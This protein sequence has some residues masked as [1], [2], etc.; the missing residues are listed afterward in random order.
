MPPPIPFAKALSPIPQDTRAS[1]P[2]YFGLIVDSSNVPVDSDDNRH[3][4]GG[5]SPPSSSV[6]STA[7]PSPRILPLDANPEFEAFRR[8]SE[9]HAF[10]LGQGHLSQFSGSGDTRNTTPQTPSVQPRDQ[11][12][13]IS[14]NSRPAVFNRE[15]SSDQ[16][17]VDP[18]RPF[19][20]SSLTLTR[21]ESPA[22]I[23]PGTPASAQR[24]EIS[25]LD[26]R[27]P[28][29]SLPH[30]RV[31]APSPL[32]LSN[33][34]HR[35]AT[36]PGKATNDD[37]RM[38]NSPDLLNLMNADPQGLLLLD[39]RVYSQFSQARIWNAL[40]LCISTTLL[41]R[42]SFT[43]NK[44]AETFSKE[45]D[46]IKFE[47][48]REVRHIV[49]YDDKSSTIRDAA[50]AVNTLKKFPRD[51]TQAQLYILQGGF[52]AFS[53]IYPHALDSAQNADP[54][55]SS[56]KG[57]SIKSL[58]PVAGGCPMP[59]A[60]TAAN[61]FFDNI[62]Q[63][64]DLIGGVGKMDLKRP[65]G[66]TAQ[67]VARLP[68]WLQVAANPA[69]HGQIVSDKFLHIEQAEQSRMQAAL[70]NGNM[71]GSGKKPC[72]IA[73]IENGSKNRYKNIWPFDHSRVKLQEIA[74]GAC[75]YINANYVQA[76]WSNKKYIATQAPIPATFDV[77]PL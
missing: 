70:S 19:S 49:V 23:S 38:I 4:R 43:V 51:Q 54:K 53:Q 75:D 15:S 60:K 36:L 39:L 33:Q 20:Q 17:D 57:L 65:A 47:K 67:H 27:H 61:P 44:L 37:L 69:D 58:L 72:Q 66:M 74:E 5:W 6:R 22:S 46:R 30:N 45:P 50:S 63:N 12:Q 9:N 73:G 76:A 21:F 28:R 71:A 7:A 68:R 64:M 55:S 10:R 52:K 32:A 31:D 25:Y 48:W 77:S 16:M 1:S 3:P 14:P 2:N 40:N 41:K 59:K 34:T 56:G 62:R 35:A 26:D 29:L 8:Q 18:P 24:N 42:A 11:A 13:S